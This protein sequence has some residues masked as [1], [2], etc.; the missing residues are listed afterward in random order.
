M[1]V[2]GLE[3]ANANAAV[4]QTAIIAARLHRQNEYQRTIEK[5]IRC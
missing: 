4:L 1:A 5:G 2:V 3:P